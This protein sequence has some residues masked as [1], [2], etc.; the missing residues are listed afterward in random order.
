VGQALWWLHNGPRYGVTFVVL[1]MYSPYP[2]T[3]RKVLYRYLFYFCD[4][5]T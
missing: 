3:L 4:R 5:F 1:L 2:A